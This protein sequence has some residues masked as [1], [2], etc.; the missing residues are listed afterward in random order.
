[1]KHTLTLQTASFSKQHCLSLWG[2]AY[3]KALL[4]KWD[5][6]CVYSALTQQMALVSDGKSKQAEIN[7]IGEVFLGMGGGG[8]GEDAFYLLS[9]TGQFHMKK[10]Q[11]NSELIKIHL[12]DL[13][14]E[15]RIS[16]SGNSSSFSFKREWLRIAR[17]TNIVI[18]IFFILKTQIILNTLQN[19]ISFSASRLTWNLTIVSFRCITV[20]S[21]FFSDFFM[22]F[23]FF[24]PPQ[25][26][27]I[28]YFSLICLLHY[29]RFVLKAHL[30]NTF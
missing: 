7:V 24:F 21:I 4:S 9:F 22:S 30:R 3:L 23:P 8:G 29:P 16:K 15:I 10:K 28:L 13:G 12:T 5:V 27:C 18:K 11:I 26:N 20:L 17:W 25:F 14:Q 19:K 6:E 2:E 1:M